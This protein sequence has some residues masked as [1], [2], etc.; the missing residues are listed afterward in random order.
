MTLWRTILKKSQE[1]LELL[2][3]LKIEFSKMQR[4][5]FILIATLAAI[6]LPAPI[7]L[8]AARTGQGY[9]FL[10]KS[11]IN[12]G[13]LVLLVP[14]LCIVAAM[15]FFE[16]RDNNTLKSLKIVP[17]SMS[18]LAASKLIVMLVVSILYSIFAFVS[19]AVFS[20]I[21]HM[22]VEQFVTKLLLCIA[23]GIMLWV[24]SLPCIALIIVFNRNYIFSVLCSFLYALMGF[25]VTNA[26]IQTE[27]PNIFMILPVNTI[28]R[29]LLPFFQN[30][31]T[32][33]YPFDIG[34]SSVNA[35]ICVVY[36]FVY[37]LVFGWIIC[38]RF[39]KWDN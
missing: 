27:A 30:L 32:A 19:T 16:E 29:W 2:E 38:N 28:N 1:V 4:R 21:G 12:L 7:S 22:A 20:M 11:V 3:L 8:L 15:L 31:D 26:T 37:A 24:A 18:L 25:I 39:K 36:L 34:P 23:T 33:K 35:I 10:Y 14:I 17:V 9:D 5:P 6:I 13:Q